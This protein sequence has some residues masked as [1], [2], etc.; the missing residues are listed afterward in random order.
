MPLLEELMYCRLESLLLSSSNTMARQWW[1]WTAG[2]AVTNG[3]DEGEA[4]NIGRGCGG[5]LGL[6]RPSQL[7]TEPASSYAAEQRAR[8]GQR[9]T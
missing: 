7:T 5:W 2:R 3:R 4:A 6:T 1:Q 8:V 9:V